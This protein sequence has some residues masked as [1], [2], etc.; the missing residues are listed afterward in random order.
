MKNNLAIF[1]T[2]YRVWQTSS[3]IL[4]GSTRYYCNHCAVYK[5]IFVTPKTLLKTQS[6][7]EKRLFFQRKKF[8]GHFFLVQSKMKNLKEQ[9]RRVQRYFDSYCASYKVIFLGPIKSMETISQK[10]LISLWKTILAK[11]FSYYPVWQTSVNIL[12]GYTKI[13]GDPC[14]RY[15]IISVTPERLLKTKF[16]WEYKRLFLQRKNFWDK[17]YLV[18]SSMKTSVNRF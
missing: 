18:L 8:L 6:F 5:I 9:I 10:R 15:K 4:L 13:F 16:F 14:A 2:Y 7:E 17:C 3:N 12:L 1:F 11:F